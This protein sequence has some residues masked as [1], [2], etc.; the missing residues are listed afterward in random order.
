MFTNS[1]FR[2]TLYWFECGVTHD[3]FS[4]LNPINEIVSKNLPRLF[5][6][7]FSV[8]LSLQC[9][10]KFL[11][12]FSVYCLKILMEIWGKVN[13][14]VL[15]PFVKWEAW[16]IVLLMRELFPVSIRLVSLEIFRLPVVFPCCGNSKM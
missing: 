10:Y 1:F 13:H 8:I 3:S 15:G 4:Q 9:G 11:S 16:Q 14:M 7:S 5:G 2:T 6:I 12:F